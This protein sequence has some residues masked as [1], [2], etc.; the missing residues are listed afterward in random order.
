MLVLLIFQPDLDCNQHSR[1]VVAP[2]P[3]GYFVSSLLVEQMLKVT[4]RFIFH[5]GNRKLAQKVNLFSDILKR[6]SLTRQSSDLQ[7][8]PRVFLMLS[9]E[10]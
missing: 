9:L 7:K 5:S 10:K 3:V 1:K 4:M 2:T 8:L 6:K